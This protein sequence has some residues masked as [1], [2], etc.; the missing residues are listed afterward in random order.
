MQ[1]NTKE[2][3][4]AIAGPEFGELQ[5]RTIIIVRAL[6]GL[7]S[8]VAGWHEHFANTF[9]DMNFMPSLVNPDV[10]L[11]PVVKPDGSQYYEYIFVYVDD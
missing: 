6:Y 9:Y 7:K 11:H 4:C 2:K 8:R 10:W 5:G 1:A 3:I